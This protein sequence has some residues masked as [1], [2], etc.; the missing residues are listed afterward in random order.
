MVRLVR[1]EVMTKNH[2][3]TREAVWAAAE[4]GVSIYTLMD[5]L[6]YKTMY[7]FLRWLGPKGTKS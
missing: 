6:G 2:N 4:R 3:Y 1:R 5:I 7:S